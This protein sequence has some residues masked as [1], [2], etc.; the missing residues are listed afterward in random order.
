MKIA[1]LILAFLGISL[2]AQAQSERE[3][4]RERLYWQYMDQL[5]GKKDFNTA[6]D[7]MASSSDSQKAQVDAWWTTS[8]D[9]EAQHLLSKIKSDLQKVSASSYGTPELIRLVVLADKVG[10]E[11]NRKQ[12]F[13][14]ALKAKLK[15]K[16]ETRALYLLLN[17]EKKLS[18]LGLNVLSVKTAQADQVKTYLDIVESSAQAPSAAQIKSLFFDIHSAG[19]T[20]LYLF[21]RKDRR[22]PCLMLMKDVNGNPVYQGSEL[23][24]LPSL[25]LSR[26]NLRF[27]HES[28][29][30]PAGIY[31]LD[32][33][34]PTADR[35]LEYGKNRR[36]IM[37]LPKSKAAVSDLL[38][39]ETQFSKWWEQNFLAKTIGRDYLRIHGTGKFNLDPASLHPTL[40]PSQGCVKMREG[41]YGNVTFNDQRLLLDQMMKAQ[42]LKVSVSSETSIR[43]ILVVIDLNQDSRAVSL[44]DVLNL[45]R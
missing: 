28:G 20:S 32:G 17:H 15:T 35:E 33:V 38:P 3:I 16:L 22:H 21:C 1:I 30:T 5:Q 45:I 34:M 6:F 36:L 26:F 23:W 41:T 27:N 12:K 10:L 44:S 24:S 31:W 2:Y 7:L 40:Y 13:I 14:K 39:Q 19:K 25:G 11:D 4:M 43:S 9:P 29:D 18:S 37:N 42:D 8:V